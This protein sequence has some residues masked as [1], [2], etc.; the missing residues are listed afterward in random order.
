MLEFIRRNR[1]LLSS[2]AFLLCSL[3]LLSVNARHPG[4]VDPL[5]RAFLELMAPFQRIASVSA[6]RVGDVWR[7]Y[8]HL[9]G[10][11]RE[12]DQMRGH[13]HE[14][15]RRATA[16]RELELMNRRLKRLLALQRRL[17]TW[18]VAA[19]VTGR[20]ASAWFESLTLDKGETDG[21]QAGMPVPAPEEVVGV[22]S[23][24]SLHAAR[25]PLLADPNSGRRDP[26]TRIRGIVPA[27]RSGAVLN[28]KRHDVQVGESHRHLAPTD[29]SEG[30]ASSADACRARTAAFLNAE[31]TPEAD[32]SCP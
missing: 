9:T 6:S 24:T 15:E 1:V 12:N 25:V 13:L 22:I 11:E 19:E 27:C 8:V 31:V 20:D 10:V 23:S 30:Q 14:L 4:R 17:P 7:G 28:V 16:Y 2:S 21:L 32:A 5:G 18:A 29:L 26:A 3:A